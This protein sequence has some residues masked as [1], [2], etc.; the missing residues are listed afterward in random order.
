MSAR[1]TTVGVTEKRAPAVAV[2]EIVE[3]NTAGHPFPV[4]WRA[5]AGASEVA[6]DQASLRLTPED[7]GVGTSL[8]TVGGSFDGTSLRVTIPGGPRGVRSLTLAGLKVERDGALHD[9]R[10]QADLG[11]RRVAVAVVAGGQAGSPVVTVPPVTPGGAVPAQLTGGSLAERVLG[12]PDVRASVLQ[13]TVVEGDS[14]EDFAAQR[15]TVS[16]VAARVAPAPED[17]EV[18]G[19]D[20]SPLWGMPGPMAGPG[21]VD[22]RAP[23]E[24][25]LTAAIEGGGPPAVTVTA[26]AGRPGQ[27]RTRGVVATGSVVRRFPDRVTVELEGAAVALPLPGPGLDARPPASVTADVT[28]RHHGLRIHPVSDAVPEGTGGLGGP[29]V[30]NGTPRVRLFPPEALVG[31]TVR[32]IGL[33]GRAPEAADLSVRLVEQPAGQP[34]KPL[35]DPGVVSV[36]PGA[37]AAA[38]GERPPVVWIDLP[39]GVAVTGPVGGVGDRHPGTLPVGGPARAP[40]AGRRGPARP[41]RHPGHR[42]RRHCGSDRPRDHG[43]RPVPPTR[44]LHRRRCPDRDK[45]PGGSGHPR[46]PH[47]PVRPVTPTAVTPAR[48]PAA[49][50]PAT[51][52]HATAVA[53]ASVAHTRGGRP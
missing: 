37:S 11:G 22:L 38:A 34:G 14:P 51:A 45:R 44:P 43:R 26:R 16:S 8:G 32:R 10:H 23:L 7:G 35:G 46:R 41:H 39:G 18:R 31:E 9:V 17:P 36:E 50:H 53:T 13:V 5:A 21:V 12:L 20:G 47:P 27:V 25:A 4:T 40:P 28:V 29:V 42:R 48:A 19:P 24:L 2:G 49:T 1:A 15:F 33:V 52:A 6:V 3:L 30:G